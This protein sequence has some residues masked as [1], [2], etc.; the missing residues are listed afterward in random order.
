MAARLVVGL[1]LA[2]TICATGAVAQTYRWVD[3]HGNV[4]YTDIRDQVPEPDRPRVPPPVEP[5]EP[6]K[7]DVTPAPSTPPR[8]R[9]P[10]AGECVLMIPG[11]PRRPSA[12]RSY[13][14]CDECRR[15]IEEMRDEEA[16][17]AA[18]IAGTR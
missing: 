4:H 3:E 11:T 7:P 14:D 2:L 1:L 16:A 10:A 5:S 12:S 9:G 13:R 17:R 6:A 18:C 15:A 8:A